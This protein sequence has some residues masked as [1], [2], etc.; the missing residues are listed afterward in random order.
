MQWLSESLFSRLYRPR[1]ARILRIFRSLE[2]F[3]WLEQ[4]W[5]YCRVSTR[6]VPFSVRAWAF[7]QGMGMCL[8]S[9]LENPI[10]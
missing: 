1:L 5:Y 9:A 2:L 4:Y 6:T 10:G 3:I 7:D 8:C